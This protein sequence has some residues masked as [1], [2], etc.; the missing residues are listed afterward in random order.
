M[1]ERLDEGW[2]ESIFSEVMRSRSVFKDKTKLYPEYLPEKL[3]HREEQLKKLAEAFKPLLTSRS[4]GIQRVILTGSYGTGKTAT[5]RVFGRTIASL[6]HKRGVRIS[7]VHVNC[8]KA[9]TL[10]QVLIAVANSLQV[11][12]PNRGLSSQ[13]M[14]KGIMSELEDKD[15]YAIIALDEF[16]YFVQSNPMSSI[17]FLVRLYDDEPLAEKRLHFIFITRNY[18]VLQ[19]LDRSVSTFFMR[20][21]IYFPP[22]SSRELRKIL[23]ERVELAF[24]D[25]TVGEDVI[26]Y[27]AH[28]EGYDREGGGSART[29]IEILMRAGESADSAGRGSVTI[30]DVRKAHV[31]VKPEIAMLQD[32]LG[33][34]GPHHLILLLAIV[35]SLKARDS[36]FVKMGEVEEMYRVLCE[37]YG[38]KP[39]RHTQVYTYVMD[40]KNMKLI[41]T[42]ASG[43]GYRGKSTLIGISSAPLDIL[44]S[45]LEEEVKTRLQVR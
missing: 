38:E 19:S 37:A 44:E 11:A 30:D 16:D 5:S 43:K 3:P 10:P 14:V 29:A 1:A 7:Y 21:V 28:L 6:A 42:K 34:L 9:R 18:S 26:D 33:A 25:G 2:A 27:I 22:Y 8:Y 23:E 32:T 40:L 45:R 31:V 12:I 35:K 24:Y 13:E 39:R 41:H 36:P 15:S 17:Y 20:N 4:G